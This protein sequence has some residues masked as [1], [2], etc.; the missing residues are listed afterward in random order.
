MSTPAPDQGAWTGPGNDTITGGD[1][2]DL[3]SPGAGADTV[4]ANGGDDIIKDET[5]QVGA[6]TLYLGAGNDRVDSLAG[7][8]SI[9][10]G[11][12]DDGVFGLGFVAGTGQV[13]IYGE[14]GNDS[15]APVAFPAII[16]G[17]LGDDTLV[18]GE[19]SDKIS[20]GD[21]IDSLVGA[22]GAD[23][24]RG[25]VGND[26]ISAKDGVSDTT[27]DCGDGTSD[28][29]TADLVAIDTVSNCESVSRS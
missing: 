14:G 20:G 10:A 11:D 21:G 16:D 28:Q 18:G 3:I 8:T 5:P 23:E 19:Y 7:G 26:Q 2:V 22:G 1:S 27:I 15:L 12:G 4:F 13:K 25:G 24:L 9:Y 29:A 17:G 6:D